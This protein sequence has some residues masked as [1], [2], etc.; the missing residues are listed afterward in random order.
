MDADLLVGGGYIDF[1]SVLIPLRNP[2][3]SLMS[4]SGKIRVF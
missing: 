4:R 3:S 2:R 1:I